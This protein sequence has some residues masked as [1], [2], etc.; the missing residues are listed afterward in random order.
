[1]PNKH[2]YAIQTIEK[3]IDPV[4]LRGVPWGYMV[5]FKDLEDNTLYTFLKG[6]EDGLLFNEVVVVDDWEVERW[7]K[8][9]TMVG[10]RFV[11]LWDLPLSLVN[12]CLGLTTMKE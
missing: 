4:L 12:L 10:G 1:M 5:L 9:N 11:S 3:T 7:Q 6:N 8:D 2:R